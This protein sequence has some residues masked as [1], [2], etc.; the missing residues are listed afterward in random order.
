MTD[1]S[2]PELERRWQESGSE[3]D[4]VALICARV[5]AG[6]LSERRLLLAAMLQY[7]PAESANRLPLPQY[8]P[9]EFHRWL[10]EFAR[11]GR[12][13]LVRLA[14]AWARCAALT[15]AEV[16]PEDNR[17]QETLRNL[18]DCVLNPTDELAEEV[19]SRW[20]S[21]AEEWGEVYGD[22]KDG[23]QAAFDAARLL[24][25]AP[26]DLGLIAGG[27][28]ESAANTC[29]PEELEEAEETEVVPWLLGHRDPL[30]ELLEARRFADE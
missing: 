11:E 10:S 27:V 20:F 3:E 19:E 9:H 16:Y 13:P 21:E 12:E 26:A 18:E 1:H 14:I 25:S 2:L 29:E 6:Q 22:D 17:P 24:R 7:P 15:W 8:H 28:Y 23:A 5:R 4:E 30:A